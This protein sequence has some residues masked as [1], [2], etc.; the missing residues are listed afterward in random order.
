MSQ[1]LSILLHKITA[2]FHRNMT[3]YKFLGEAWGAQKPKV[4]GSKPPSNYRSSFPTW[5]TLLPSPNP[6]FIFDF[7]FLPS[8]LSENL[9]LSNTPL[10]SKPTG[11]QL[12]KNYTPNA[13]TK[14][15]NRGKE[16]NRPGISNK[17]ADIIIR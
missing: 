10:I 5:Y 1:V 16:R 12:P 2:Y 9:I 7:T 6:L 15:W 14:T 13:K 8:Q 3:I 4:P 17:S 11:L